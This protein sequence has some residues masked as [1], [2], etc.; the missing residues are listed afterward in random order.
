MCIT[1][2]LLFSQIRAGSCNRAAESLT[3]GPDRRKEAALICAELNPLSHLQ[4]N[5]SLMTRDKPEKGAWNSRYNWCLF[6]MD[7]YIKTLQWGKVI[8][9]P[10]LSRASAGDQGVDWERRGVKDPAVGRQTEYPGLDVDS[11]AS[12]SPA[13]R[14]GGDQDYLPPWRPRYPIPGQAAHLGGQ[15]DSGRLQK[16]PQQAKL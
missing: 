1:W 10:E 14:H 4:A 12:T 15:G 2:G 6:E 11:P 8:V 7:F 5:P 16:C 9:V 13:T 3:F